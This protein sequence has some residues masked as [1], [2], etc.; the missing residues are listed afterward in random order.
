MVVA[1]NLVR[2]RDTG[3]TSSKT[4]KPLNRSVRRPAFEK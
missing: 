2:K 3:G 4:K 1:K